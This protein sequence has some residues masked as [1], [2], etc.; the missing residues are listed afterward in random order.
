M[1]QTRQG[2]LAIRKL[3]RGR[4]VVNRMLKRE[5][6]LVWWAGETLLMM[7]QEEWKGEVR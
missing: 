1:G 4:A 2:R 7:M 6:R 3:S 5:G